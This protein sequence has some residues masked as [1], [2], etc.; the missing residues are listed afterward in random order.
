MPASLSRQKL[1]TQKDEG[2]ASYLPAVKEHLLRTSMKLCGIR[3][4]PVQ[5]DILYEFVSY[6]KSLLVH[7]W[8]NFL[9]GSAYFPLFFFHAACEHI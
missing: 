2:P 3:D 7:L 5:T 9:L 8:P 1:A 4:V 6:Q